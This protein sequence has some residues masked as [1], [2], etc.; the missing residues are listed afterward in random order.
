MKLKRR[1]S[2]VY[3]AG[4]VTIQRW[5]HEWWLIAHGVKMLSVR[6]LNEA[7]QLLPHVRPYLHS[8]AETARE[9]ES[10]ERCKRAGQV[11]YQCRLRDS[12]RPPSAIPWAEWAEARIGTTAA[13]VRAACVADAVD[14]AMEELETRFTAKQMERIA[15]WLKDNGYAA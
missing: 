1:A 9:R 4:P 12:L 11:T 10:K 7:R 15:D 3:D 5:C 6:T 14:D 2:G 8:A 13:A